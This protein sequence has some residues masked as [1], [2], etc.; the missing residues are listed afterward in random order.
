MRGQSAGCRVEVPEVRTSLRS[1]RRLRGAAPAC[2]LL[3]LRVLL[4]GAHRV[5]QMVRDEAGAWA[6]GTTRVEGGRS[7]GIRRAGGR[8][9]AR[10]RSAAEERPGES[11]DRPGRG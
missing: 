8:R 11:R 3:E 6:H 4:P 9:V 7:P 1:A 2:V 10:A 5:V